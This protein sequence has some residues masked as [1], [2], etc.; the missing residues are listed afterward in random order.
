VVDS[1]TGHDSLRYVT[2]CYRPWTSHRCHHWF[3]WLFNF[4]AAARSAAFLFWGSH[5][6]GQPL[7][8]YFSFPDLLRS[9]TFG[10]DLPCRRCYL[11][12]F[13]RY[14]HV[15][16]ASFHSI[17]SCT[18]PSDSVLSLRISSLWLQLSLCLLHLSLYQLHRPHKLL[19]LRAFLR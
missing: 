10:P 7:H 13:P 15:F 16:P 17:C 3:T 14:V 18:A 1:E 11:S 4:L 2:L 12:T 8:L 6:L 19:P 9:F 5:S